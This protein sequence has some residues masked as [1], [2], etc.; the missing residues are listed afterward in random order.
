MFG[1]WLCVCVCVICVMH[2]CLY[3]YGDKCNLGVLSL[4]VIHFVSFIGTWAH[5][6]VRVVGKRAPGNL[7]SP[8]C[9]HHGNDNHPQQWLSFYVDAGAQ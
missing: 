8:Q 1:V 2:M 3:T 4:R 9:S 7:M 5:P 6:L